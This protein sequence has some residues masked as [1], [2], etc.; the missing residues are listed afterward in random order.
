MNA[1]LDS[2]IAV[3]EPLPDRAVRGTLEPR[4]RQSHDEHRSRAD[5]STDYDHSIRRELLRQRADNWHEQNDQKI[6]DGGELTGRR[7]VPHFAAAELG[8]H[9]IHL[10]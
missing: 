8:R 5:R 10:Q 2:E 1:T 7:A 4:C 6:I 3:A 9:A